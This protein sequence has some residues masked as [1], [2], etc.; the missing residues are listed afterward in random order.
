MTIETVIKINL[1]NYEA[2]AKLAMFSQS[3]RC[4]AALP[5]LDEAETPSHNHHGGNS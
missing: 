3:Q 4:A 5:M 2:A 1:S